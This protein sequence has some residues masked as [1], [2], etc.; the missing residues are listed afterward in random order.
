M[1]PPAPSAPRK[2]LDVFIGEV[3]PKWWER[4]HFRVTR[5]T[6]QSFYVR[7]D[8]GARPKRHDLADWLPWLVERGREGP[9]VIDGQLMRPPSAAPFFPGDPG[10]LPSAG[11]GSDENGARDRRVLGAVREVL[12]TFTIKRRPDSP[13]GLEIYRFT[14][15]GWS[16]WYTVE[17]DPAWQVEPTCTCLDQQRQQRKRAGVVC[18]HVVAVLLKFPEHR[19]Q[20][21]DL[22][23]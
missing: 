22:L 3:T 13:E 2:G 9:L 23:L 17:V 1:L 16:A 20:L 4:R 18:R 15:R 10:A 21:I 7:D 11:Q 6:S 12:S 5:V 8:S 14:R 19:H